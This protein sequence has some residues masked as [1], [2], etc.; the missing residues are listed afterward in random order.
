MRQYISGTQWGVWLWTEVKEGAEL[1][2]TR[3]HLLKAPRWSVYL[4]WIHKPDPYPGT[5]LHDHPVPFLSIVL[6]GGYTEERPD[7]RHLRRWFNL[8]RCNDRHRIISVRPGTLTLCL[9]GAP[10]T[11]RPWGFHTSKGFVPWT[12]Y[13]RGG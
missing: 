13:G 7:G 10:R 9:A 1:Y 6:R 8:L 12:E 4:H 5:A 3:F 2:L 11:D